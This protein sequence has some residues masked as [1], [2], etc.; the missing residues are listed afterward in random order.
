MWITTGEVVSVE[1]FGGQTIEVQIESTNGRRRPVF[2][3]PA[4]RW[5]RERI[6]KGGLVRLDHHC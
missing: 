6:G 3:I 1:R 5:G 2:E 4:Q